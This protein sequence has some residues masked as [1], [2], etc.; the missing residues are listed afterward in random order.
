MNASAPYNAQDLPTGMNFNRRSFI[1]LGVGAAFSVPANRLM[2]QQGMGGHTA[3]PTPRG[4]RSGR[5]FNSHF[6]DVAASAGLRAPVIYGD[7]EMKKYIVGSTGGA[8]P[9]I[10]YDNDGWMDLFVLSGTRIAGAP[11]GATNRLY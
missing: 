2:A 1:R 3:K 9:F 4:E 5:P 7:E 8:W 6:V 10:A 11:E